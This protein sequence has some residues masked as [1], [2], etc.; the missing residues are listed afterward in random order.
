VREYQPGD[1]YRRIHWGLSHKH[2]QL[3]S[4]TFEQPLTADL[5]LVLDLDRR[6]HWGRGDDSTVDC[7]VGLA[8]S[9]ADQVLKRGRSVGL[10]ANDA[11]GTLIDMTTDRQGEEAVL[12]YLAAA[13]ATGV[14]PLAE[15]RIWERIRR[16]DR[17]AVAV[18]TPSPDPGWVL[19]ARALRERGG[20][21]IVFYL[22]ASTFGAPEAEL[23][24]DLGADVDLYVVRRGDVFSRLVRTRDAIRLD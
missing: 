16:L 11:R 3:M 4:K 15:A 13:G 24:F 21:L 2:G 20:A 12:D 8:A 22:D 23:G 5:W 1:A 9:V 17:R 10:V 14:R 19:N 7:A 6:A 18:V